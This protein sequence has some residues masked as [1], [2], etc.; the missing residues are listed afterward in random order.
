M[1]KDQEP[2]TLSTPLT[3]GPN[4]TG[5]ELTH[6]FA[7]ASADLEHKNSSL[8]SPIKGDNSVDVFSSPS[9]A[10]SP[11]LKYKGNDYKEHKETPPLH[12]ETMLSMGED[13][14][15]VPPSSAELSPP[16]Q[17]NPTMDGSKQS[18]NK[19]L[20]RNEASLDF[21]A[22]FIRRIVH[23]V[24]ENLREVLRCRFGDLIIQSAQQFLTLQ[25]LLKF[26][27]KRLLSNGFYLFRM[28]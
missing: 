11:F 13:E 14:S 28:N 20:P 12:S 1:T 4:S 27:Y 2:R 3:G 16:N 6:G 8:F 17:S 22:E 5:T 19:M 10:T 26:L 24:E 9:L 23:D 21:Q 7:N 15:E 25:V 18:D